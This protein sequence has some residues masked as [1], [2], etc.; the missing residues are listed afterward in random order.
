MVK[1][2][3]DN[4][5]THPPKEGEYLVTG[6]NFRCGTWGLTS[7]KGGR[8]IAF[9]QDV[10]DGVSQYKRPSGNEVL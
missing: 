8:W 4:E 10:T 1:F 3:R 9:D 6:P 2:D 5:E 7:W